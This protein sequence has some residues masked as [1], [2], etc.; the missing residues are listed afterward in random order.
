VIRLGRVG[1]LV[2]VAWCG[3][4]GM[5]RAALAARGPV[6]VPKV[7]VGDSDGDGLPEVSTSGV[8]GGPCACRCPIAGAATG[9]EAAGISVAGD[10]R[11]ALV[12][13]GT[14]LAAAVDPG[15]PDAGTRPEVGA[16]LQFN[17]NGL[18]RGGPAG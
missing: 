4:V 8:A 18:G 14:R 6:E 11:S 9:A 3:V 16:R 12:V 5:P 13:C 10:T 15:A 7:S 2:L 17:P 1:V